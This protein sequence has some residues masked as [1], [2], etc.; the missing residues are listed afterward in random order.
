MSAAWPATG[1]GE[2]EP[3]A[4]AEAEAEAGVRAAW[5]MRWL[6]VGLALWLL[7]PS[8]AMAQARARMSSR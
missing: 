4:E 7:L 1:A 6:R 3:E 2:P 8:K 5:P